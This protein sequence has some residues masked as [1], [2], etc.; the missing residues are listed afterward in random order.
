MPGRILVVDDVATNR[1]ILKAKLSTAYY[2]VLEAD[3]GNKAL[4]VAHRELPDVILL[5]VMMPDIDGFEVC[6]QLKSSPETSHIPV[7][8]V[9]AM[10]SPEERIRGLNAGAD[11]FLTKPINDLALFARVRN[12]MR[13]KMMFDE[14]RMRDT[15]SREMGLSD[16]LE[17]LDHSD[18][19]QETV[20]LSPPDCEIGK[21][22]RESILENLDV[23]VIGT[24]SEREAL[25][26]SSLELPDAYVVSQNMMEN[27]D[28]L[29]LVSAL[30]SKPETRQ[31]A[32]LFVV[33]DGT[34]E[35]AARGLDLGASDYIMA[36][37]DPNELVVRLRSQLRRKKYSDRLRSNMRDGLKM[38]VIDPLTGLYNR[39]YATQHMS[40]II[41]RAVESKGEFSVMMMDLDRF[42][43]VNDT[44]GHDAGDLVLKELSRRLQENVRGVDLVARMGGEE[45]LVVMPDAGRFVAEKAAERLRSSIESEPFILKSGDTLSVTVSVGVAIGSAINCDADDLIKQADQALYRAKDN[46]R[47]LVS[48]FASAA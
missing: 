36:P 14:L 4:E 1:L 47:N 40:K 32:I 44:L 12:L 35:T 39:R 11:D 18:E 26:I 46:G 45:F 42:K 5:D 38:A 3:C 6:K 28:G 27:G 48:F 31:S 20:M 16:F 2:D 17:S 7:V 41:D 30:R 13:V 15:T 10:G 19:G 29:R 34:V 9:T 23:K 37:F 21:S 8:M 33:S 25:N 43:L 24:L 22:W